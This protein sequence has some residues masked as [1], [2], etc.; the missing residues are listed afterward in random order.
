[1]SRLV[2]QHTCPFCQGVIFVQYGAT[3][4]GQAKLSHQTPTCE[5]LK[6]RLTEVMGREP[7]VDSREHVVVVSL[8][9]S[10]EGEA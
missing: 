3:A 2:E 8:A 1:V 6:A 5:G 10:P 4:D 7:V 9:R